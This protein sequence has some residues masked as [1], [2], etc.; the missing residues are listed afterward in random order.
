[1][2]VAEQ[3]IDPGRVVRFAR[4]SPRRSAILAGAAFLALVVVFWISWP[5][6]VALGLVAGVLATVEVGRLMHRAAQAEPLGDVSD[7]GGGGDEDLRQDVR[8]L[9]VRLGDDWALFGR[10]AV[11]VTSSQQASVAGLQRELAIPTARAQHLVTLLE[12][13]GFVGPARGARR[14]DVLLPPERADELE[15]LIRL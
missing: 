10:A 15:R 13:E 5:A 6:G 8:R 1:M 9:R 11:Q 14:R 3:G 12:R 7:L 2:V 4:V